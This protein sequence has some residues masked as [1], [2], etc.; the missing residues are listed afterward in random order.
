MKNNRR[1]RLWAHGVL[2]CVV[3][4]V[5]LPAWAAAAG[6]DTAGAIAGAHQTS[7][8]ATPPAV[9]T[10]AAQSAAVEPAAPQPG[11]AAELMRLQEDTVVLKAQLKKLDAQAQVAERERA[12]ERLNG[13]VP[14]YDEVRVLATQSLGTATS[15]TISLSDGTEVEARA[16]E[17]LPNDMRVVAIRAGSVTV[18]R[19]GGKRMVLPVW[20]ARGSSRT[21]PQLG[22]PSMT[23]IP[24]P[25]TLPG[26]S[27]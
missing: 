22:G 25:P 8:K 17:T 7:V 1:C 11:A 6:T 13:A 15:A 3:C 5:L 19:Q 20:S 12:L 18:E 24:P 27:R 4:L 9:P 10:A 16:G 21:G 26:L 2:S 14:S 23:M